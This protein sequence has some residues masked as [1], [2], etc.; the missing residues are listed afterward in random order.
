MMGRELGG[1]PGTLTNHFMKLVLQRAQQFMKAK[2]FEVWGVLDPCANNGRVL[3]AAVAYGASYAWG[4]EYQ[5]GVGLR[6]VYR[7]T[8]ERLAKLEMDTA[9]VKLVFG[10][11]SATLSSFTMPHSVNNSKFLYMLCEGVPDEAVERCYTLAR[12][13]PGVLLIA[14]VPSRA[15]GS[16]F[17]LRGLEREVLGIL[18]EGWQFSW[19]M[20]VNACGRSKKTM[21]F[22]SRV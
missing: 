7:D 6:D 10:I 16:K 21:L 20:D 5:N 19:K 14:A 8:R 3:F 4:W 1:M 18:G 9:K 11:D 13:D 15:T 17:I 22:F 12:D 2:G